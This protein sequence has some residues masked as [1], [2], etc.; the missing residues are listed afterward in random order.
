MSNDQAIAAD[1][2]GHAG[3]RNDERADTQLAD[4]QPVR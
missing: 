1:D 4:D 3:I 2:V